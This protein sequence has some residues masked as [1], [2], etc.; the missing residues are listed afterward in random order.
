MSNFL[1]DKLFEHTINRQLNAASDAEAL[2]NELFDIMEAYWKPQFNV[3]MSKKDARTI[4][5]RAFS[6]WDLFIKKLEKEKY[7]LA[8]IIK[9]NSYK[10][11][12]M[13]NPELKR[14]YDS[15][16]A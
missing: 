15:L 1:D 5:D 16:K 8:D 7:F 12:F 14:I 13:D 6:L 9:D 2:I 10:Q 4:I 11:A 3:G